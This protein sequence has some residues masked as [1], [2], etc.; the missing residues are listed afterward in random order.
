MTMISRLFGLF[1]GF[2]SLFITGLE[3]KNPEALLENEKEKLRQSLAKYK[4]G[5]ASQAALAERLKRQVANQ[6]QQTKNLQAKVTA[7]LNAG[8]K[9]DAA[10]WALEYQNVKKDLEETK[11]QHEMAETNYRNTAK[12]MEITVKEAQAK[13]EKVSRGIAR[14]KINEATAE[15]SEMASNMIGQ[16]GTTGGDGLNRLEELVEEQ[17][18]KAAGR[19]RVAQGSMDMSQINL[20]A[21]EQQALADQA[22]ADFAA[23]KGILLDSKS[24]EPTGIVTEPASLKTMGN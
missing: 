14:K 24:P 4:T 8:N 12:T 19:A 2:L 13:I 17:A 7:F 20:K 9:T 1:R 15:M 5:L 16:I 21:E 22:L 10:N 3:S 11:S 18:D 6:E 23:E